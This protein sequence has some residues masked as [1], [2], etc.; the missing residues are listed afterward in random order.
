M[1]KTRVIPTLLYKDLGLVKGVGFDSGR[2]VGAALPAVKV[3]NARDVDELVLLDIAA[4]PAGREPDYEL[5][6]DLAGECRVPFAVGGGIACPEAIRGLLLSGADKVVINSAA[7]DR[8]GLIEAAAGRYGS[9]CVVAA[10][11]ARPWGDGDYQ[12]FSHC[13]TRPAGRR[14]EDWARE[15][16]RLGAGEILL[17]AVHRDGAMEGY[18]LEL[19]R[20]VSEAV[21]VPVIAAGGAGSYRHFLEAI[22]AGASA[23]AAA[24][25][26]HFTEQT[27][28]GAKGFLAGHGVAVRNARIAAEAAA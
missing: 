27:P 7:Y 24:S 22:R 23:V 15:L 4:T 26:F 20:R 5:V 19:I 28:A 12:C 8:P 10:V 21:T 6:A 17:T 25:L 13:A 2:R 14:P 1:L 18:D 9:Q 3:Y 16:E 11:D